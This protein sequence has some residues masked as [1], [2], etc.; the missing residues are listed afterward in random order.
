MWPFGKSALGGGDGLFQRESGEKLQHGNGERAYRLPPVLLK[1]A[2]RGID[3][4]Y[5]AREKTQNEHSGR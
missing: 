4:L 5:D 2:Y 3:G 1:N